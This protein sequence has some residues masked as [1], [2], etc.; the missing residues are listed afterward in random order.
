MVDEFYKQLL[1]ILS[2]MHQ[3]HLNDMEK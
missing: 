3:D 2:K 1:D